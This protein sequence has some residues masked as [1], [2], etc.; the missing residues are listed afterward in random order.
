MSRISRTTVRALLTLIKAGEIRTR[1]FPDKELVERLLSS[2]CIKKERITKS[3]SRLVLVHEEGLR[4]CCGDYNERLKDL[5]GYLKDLEFGVKALKPSEEIARFGRDHLAKRNLWRGF[6][7]KSNK[8]MTV[9]YNNHTVLID[10]ESPLLVEKPEL[11]KLSFEDVSLWVVENYEC[12]QN[13]RWMGL[14]PEGNESSLIICRWP[15]SKQARLA[16]GKWPVRK[17]H[18]FGDLDPAGINIFQTEFAD[19]F[20]SDAFEVPAS[21]SVDIRNGSSTLFHN[22]KKY[23]RISG[24][25]QKIQACIETILEQQKGLPQEYYLIKACSD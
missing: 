14:F 6:F 5:E 17:K 2:G 11:L 23:W 1:E 4:I 22:Q 19:L 16:Y 24:R 13:I 8:P 18:Y 10:T 20:G 25:T 21:F 12:F 3:S 15:A 9:L 7:L